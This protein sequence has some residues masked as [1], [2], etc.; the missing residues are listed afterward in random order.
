MEIC[1]PIRF[2]LVSLLGLSSFQFRKNKD[3]GKEDVTEAYKIMNGVENVDKKSFPL[4][5][6]LE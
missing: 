4:G 1:I 6:I 3:I 2:N 5:I